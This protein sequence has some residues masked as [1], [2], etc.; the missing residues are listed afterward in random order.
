MHQHLIAAAQAAQASGSTRDIV[1]VGAA[2]VV[3][4]VLVKINPFGRTRKSTGGSN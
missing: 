3:F 2:L 4:A 1:A